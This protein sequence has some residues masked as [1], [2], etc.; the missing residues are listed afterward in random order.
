MYCFWGAVVPRHAFGLNGALFLHSLQVL[1][2]RLAGLALALIGRK[3]LRIPARVGC[4]ERSAGAQSGGDSERWLGKRLGSEK[5]VQ[6]PLENP[7]FTGL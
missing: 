3:S 5:A 1:G 2:R 6:G 4:F 7:V